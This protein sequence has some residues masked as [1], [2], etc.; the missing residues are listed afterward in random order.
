MQ[1]TSKESAEADAP[2]ED[3]DVEI[4]AENED[5]NLDDNNLLK[6]TKKHRLTFNEKSLLREKG[7]WF[8]YTTFPS[9]DLKGTK[10]SAR[11]DI[12]ILMNA[13]KSWAQK[14]YP[15]MHHKDLLRKCSNLSGKTAIK[16]LLGCMRNEFEIPR[17]VEKKTVREIQNLA[18]FIEVSS[19]ISERIEAERV[20]KIDKH[21]RS[22]DISLL[23]Q[24]EEFDVGEYEEEEGEAEE[25]TL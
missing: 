11:T 19:A 21:D 17:T 16:S 9:L 2:V 1:D 13:Y 10:S 12:R 23:E 15:K 5:D 25:G 7:L 14:L 3:V 4:E 22:H 20:K 24:D 6:G 8:V 18:K